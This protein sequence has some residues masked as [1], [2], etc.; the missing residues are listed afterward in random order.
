MDICTLNAY[1]QIPRDQRDFIGLL[2]IKLVGVTYMG[3]VARQDEI[4]YSLPNFNG[5]IVE[6]WQWISNRK[7]GHPNR[8]IRYNNSSLEVE[9]C[10]E[11]ISKIMH[12]ILVDGDSGP[13]RLAL[14]W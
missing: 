5:A 13:V 3:H 6:V 12:T 10:T 8:G 1:R 7:I 4:T 14:S 2:L 9:D 11:C